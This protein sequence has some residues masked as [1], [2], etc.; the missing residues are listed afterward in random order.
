VAQLFSLGHIELLTFAEASFV[1]ESELVRRLEMSEI[2][3]VSLGLARAGCATR[4]NA[5]LIDL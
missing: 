3:A 1:A 5:E 4:A 2:A